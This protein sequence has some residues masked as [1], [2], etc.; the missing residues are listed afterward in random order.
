MQ[1]RLSPNSNSASTPKTNKTIKESGELVDT[2]EI[3]SLFG[4]NNIA[5]TTK[6][7][8]LNNS[9][10]LSS[11]ATTSISPN[12]YHHHSNN[13]NNKFNFM[14]IES[15]STS[16]TSS[17]E[18]LLQTRFEQERKELFEIY[19]SLDFQK[20]GTITIGDLEYGLQYNHGLDRIYSPELKSL[21]SDIYNTINENSL[22]TIT[23][24]SS[25]I[26]NHP[27]LVNDYK[28]CKIDF[29]LFCSIMQD[30]TNIISRAFLGKLAIPNW[31]DFCKIVEEIFEEVRSNQSG[32]VASYIPE[33]AEV[34]PNLY[35]LSITT[36]DG[37]R[38]SIGDADHD[39]TIQ[40]CAKPFSY[41][42]ACEDLGYEK[43]YEHV[44]FEPSGVSFNAFTLDDRNKPH[45]PMINSGAITVC[46]LVKPKEMLSKRFTY[47][48]NFFSKSAGGAKIGFH[49]ATF[50]SEK[51]T[52]DRNYA[53]TYYM[54]ENG[55]FPGGIKVEESLDLYFQ[56]CSIQVN[57]STLA[58]MAATFANG[59]V[60]P[61]TNSKVF[62]SPNVKYAL[63]LMLSSGMYDW[64]GEWACTVG[65]PAKSGVSGALAVVIP[66]VLGLCIFSPRLDKRGN[67]VRGVEFSV[68]ASR[69]FKWS[70]FDRLVQ[71]IPEE[72][73]EELAEEAATP[74][75]IVS[76]I[77]TNSNNINASTDISGL[78][79]H[80]QQQEQLGEDIDINSKTLEQ[81][82]K[83]ESLLKINTKKLK[84]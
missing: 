26:N 61:L 5:S 54:Q 40:S 22:S 34:D 24:N 48:S 2:P 77:N 44:G 19:S 66:S 35:G 70:I 39:F 16:Q 15:A 37:Q 18:F 68:K 6:K 82:R 21:L 76:N 43:V 64:S 51:L 12:P 36:V 30:E 63:Q 29:D 84:E 32:D 38:F 20:K 57:C 55:V 11:P 42:I 4:N 59:G 58:S 3:I 74:I 45:N 8:L 65:L 7:E 28:N 81:K 17:P 83:R 67:S 72:K 80:I 23:N 78:D 71:D 79:I 73:E 47:V 31:R 9:N 50:L 10:T 13:L 14:E 56:V 46:S 41:C 49:N 69:R 25:S 60:C 75:S 33:L 27:H 1:P 62:S 52:G 53:L